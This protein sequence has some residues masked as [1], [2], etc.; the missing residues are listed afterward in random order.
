MKPEDHEF[1]FDEWSR[2]AEHDPDAFEKRREKLMQDFIASCR[3]E[4]RQSMEKLMFR[5]NAERRRASNPM[6]ATLKLLAMAEDKLFAELVPTIRGEKCK[7]KN[8]SKTKGNIYKL[9]VEK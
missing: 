1:N 7:A 9:N 5:V 3:E 2:L 6:A 8:I 4:S